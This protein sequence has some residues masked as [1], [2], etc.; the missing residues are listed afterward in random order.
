M[1]FRE[2]SS[3]ASR[4]DLK[5]SSTA[6][7]GDACFERFSHVFTPDEIE[8][9]LKEAIG[10]N[11]DKVVIRIVETSRFPLPHGRLEFPLDGAVIGPSARPETPFLWRGRLC[12]PSGKII[13]YWIRVCVTAPALAIRA[14]LD[15]T[16]GEVITPGQV[17]VFESQ[18]CPL[19]PYANDK[20]ENYVGL[21]AKRGIRR[22][23]ALSLSLFEQVPRV[24]HGSLVPVEAKFGSTRL[25]FKAVA[26]ADGR[27][28]QRISLTNVESH[29]HFVGTVGN[30]GTVLVGAVVR[31]IPDMAPQKEK[32]H[33]IL[34][35]TSKAEL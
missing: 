35:T 11:T 10:H 31:K 28:G 24:L 16:A 20:S 14:K 19:R 12:T 15:L 9:I 29:R 1:S 2:L 17:E 21:R 13:P 4:F 25:V 27:A 6:L 8:P 3:W 23:T 26:D 18:A 34:R 30:D 7:S 5:L 33:E 22:G 32:N